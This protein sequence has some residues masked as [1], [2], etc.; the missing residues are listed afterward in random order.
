M[1]IAELTVLKAFLEDLKP[2]GQCHKIFTTL[3]FYSKLIHQGAWCHAEFFSNMASIS[4]RNSD[5]MLLFLTP[6]CQ[7]GSI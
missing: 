1:S 5:W 3:I 4:L 6:R 7:Q 2:K